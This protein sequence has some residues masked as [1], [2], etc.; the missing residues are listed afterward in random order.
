MLILRF[1]IYGFLGW[2]TEI[3]WTSLYNFIRSY[4][5]RGAPPEHLAERWR[6]VG[7][8]YLWMLPIYGAGGLLFERVHEAVRVHP[9][10]LRGLVYA[11]LCFA[12]EYI[13]GWLLRRL[14]GRCPWDYSWAWLHIHG[15]IRP[16]YALAWMALGLVF[17]RLHN[18]LI[19][20]GPCISAAAECVLT[21][22]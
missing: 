1:F 16:D 6:L 10:W 18:M 2:C 7:Q 19:R 5:A 4:L 22:P 14:T 20:L 9:F 12:I 17:E 13:S 11:V 8:T 15:L 3:L 21:Q